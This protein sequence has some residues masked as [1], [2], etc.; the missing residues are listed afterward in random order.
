MEDD[1]LMGEMHLV[2]ATYTYANI[3]MMSCSFEA[4]SAFG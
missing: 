1:S 2:H 3:F 4:P